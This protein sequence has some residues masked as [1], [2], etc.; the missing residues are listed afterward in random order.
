MAIL[1]LYVLAWSPAV[2]TAIT[3]MAVNVS[4]HR[5]AYFEAA[6]KAFCRAVV[7]VW[8]AC[9]FP[10]GCGSNSKPIS[11]PPG[12][13]C[14]GAALS[15]TMRD[16][17]THQP[18]TQGMAILESGTQLGVPSIYSFAPMQQVGTNAQ[19]EFSLCAQS[20]PSPSVLVLQAT[21]PG[22]KA[23]P[24]YVTA[25]TM[26]ADLGIVSMGG[27]TGVCGLA[28]EQQTAKPATITGVVTSSPIGI[29]GTLIPQY[30]MN[31][32]DGSKTPDGHSNLWA[33]AMPVFGASPILTFS[34]APGDC[35]GTEPFCFAYTFSVPA[36]SPFYPIDGGTMGMAAPPGY[37]IH[38]VPTASFVCTP[39]LADASFQSDGKSFL[40][41]TEGAQ[42]I[43]QTIDFANCR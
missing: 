35:G 22:G 30:V 18:I 26:A 24:P 1:P 6:M 3:L 4:N 27:C 32:L 14:S 42:L 40:V 16:S 15:G 33:L 17:L 21:D 23:Y 5:H 38:S 25:V 9:I 19:G 12:N 2:V 13:S 34:S 41:T 10:S 8:V 31:A 36:Q 7:L 37:L 20:L 39:P 28:G 11:A 43:A 29:T